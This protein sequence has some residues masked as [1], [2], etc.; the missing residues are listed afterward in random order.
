MVC[1][2]KFHPGREM[3]AIL[4][5]KAVLQSFFDWGLKYFSI[6]PG[7]RTKVERPAA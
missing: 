7:D 6:M 5:L 1:L 3:A 2:V 4:E